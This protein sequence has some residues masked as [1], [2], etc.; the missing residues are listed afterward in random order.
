MKNSACVYVISYSKTYKKV[1]VKVKFT[2]EQATKA[3]KGV[4]RYSPTVSLTSTLDEGGWS[5]PR[6]G[7]FTPGKDPVPIV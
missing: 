2:L 5:I 3:Q 6:P 1:K 4:W 7:R